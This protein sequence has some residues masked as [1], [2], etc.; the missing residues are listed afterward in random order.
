MGATVIPARGNRRFGACDGGHGGGGIGRVAHPGR[1]VTRADDDEIVV[2]HVKALHA[3][4]FGDELLLLRA[5][6]K[7]VARRRLRFATRAG[8]GGLDPAVRN[9]AGA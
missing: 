4:A 6:M 5:G 3:V 7:D 8:G 1:I 9:A 2:H